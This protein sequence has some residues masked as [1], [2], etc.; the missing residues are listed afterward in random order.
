MCFVHDLHISIKVIISLYMSE[1]RHKRQEV[2]CFLC[3]RVFRSF[4]ELMEYKDHV[5]AFDLHMRAHCAGSTD[6][7]ET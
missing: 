6:Q 4:G 2:T 3:S 7:P 1:S 5:H